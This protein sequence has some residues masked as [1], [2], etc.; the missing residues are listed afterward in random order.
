MKT[1]S[2]IRHAKSSWDNPGLSDFERP[3]NARGMEDAPRIG[4]KL[5]EL[6]IV[7]DKLLCSTAKRAR[8]TLVLLQSALH[9]DEA[10][11]QYLDSLYGASSFELV[12]IIHS[13]PNRIQHL[14]IIAHNPGLEMLATQLLAKDFDKFPTGAV[15]Q[16]SLDIERWYD[17]DNAHGVQLHFLWPKNL[18]PNRKVSTNY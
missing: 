15:L 2:L 7:F 8:E 18:L 10:R 12:E 13:T 14:A 11:I 3:L 5:K 1:L 6:D 4:Q 9:L 17:I 16:L